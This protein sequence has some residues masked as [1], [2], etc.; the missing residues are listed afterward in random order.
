MNKNKKLHSNIL[1]KL[2]FLHPTSIAVPTVATVLGAVAIASAVPTL[3]VST[4]YLKRNGT[5]T[6]STLAPISNPNASFTLFLISGSSC[7]ART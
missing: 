4:A 7:V 1:M 5:Q 6:F 2:K 3:N